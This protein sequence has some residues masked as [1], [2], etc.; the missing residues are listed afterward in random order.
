MADPVL[1][2][3]DAELTVGDR[4]LWSGLSLDVQ[5]GEFIAVLGSNGSGKTSLLRAI[6]GERELTHGTISFAEGKHSIGYVPQHYAAA[7]GA[8]VRARD[9]ISLAIDGNRFGFPWPSRARTAQVNATLA[10]VGATD[11]ARVPVASLSGGQQQRIRIGQALA[12][13][14][15]VLLCDEPFGSLDPRQQHVAAELI[16]RRRLDHQTAVLLVT[17]DINPIL[18]MV[19]R[20]LYLAGGTFR[21]G[22]VAEVMRSE[23]LTELYGAPVEVVTVGDRMFVLGTDEDPHEHGRVHHHG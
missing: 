7:D 3:A 1:Q 21:I 13:D 22:T 23:T 14:P 20:V 2:I 19:D 9:L 17:H 12:A 6:L 11:L 8:P 18:G 15:C 10:Q 5:P 16:N 4:T